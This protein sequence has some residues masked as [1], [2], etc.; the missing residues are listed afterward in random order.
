[1]SLPR[2][3]YVVGLIGLAPFLAGPGWLAFRH[4][5]LP[6]DLDLDRAWLLYVAIVASFM[7]GTFWGFALPAADGLGGKVGMGISVLLMLLAWGST[8]LA[9]RAALFALI[10][11]YLLL[12]LADFWRERV[13][14]TIPGYFMLRTVLTVGVLLALSWRILLGHA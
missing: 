13:L 14:D 7:A 10:G 6:L 8:L 5:A 9:F 1:M 3:I 11:V 12:L 2:W 4:G